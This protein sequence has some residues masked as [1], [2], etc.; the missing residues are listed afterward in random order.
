MMPSRAPASIDMLHTVMRSSIDMSRIASPSY[1]IACWSAPPWPSFA[2]IERITSFAETPRA[3]R[4]S[5]RTRIFFGFL[6]QIVC[7]ASACP[8]SPPMPNASAP[9]APCVEVCESPQRMMTPGCVSPCSGPS[10][11]WMPRSG[12]SM[13]KSRMPASSELRSRIRI[14][15]RRSSS[16][17]S[18][19]RGP[20]L[21]T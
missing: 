1:S 12:S 10:R 18:S 21:P 4:P 8:S 7:V 2:T 20:A 9:S 15:L 3:R 19:M 11:C 6:C 14:I 5:T 16:T 17:T 13:P